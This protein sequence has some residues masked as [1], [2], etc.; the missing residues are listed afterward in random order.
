MGIQWNRVVVG[1]AVLTLSGATTF[2][3]T[4]VLRDGRRIR[5][6][7]RTV[8][9]GVIE[10]AV[11]DSGRLLRID[12]RE[13]AR[14]ELDDEIG[15]HGS[16][17]PGGRPR[18]LRER[19]VSVAANVAWNDTGIDVRAGQD[20][21]FAARGRVRWGPDRRD[22]AA[23]EKN[24]PYNAYRPIPGRPAAALIGKVGE[25]SSDYFFIG[26]DTGPVRMRTRGR[27]FLAINDDYLLDNSG[28][29]TVTVYY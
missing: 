17:R 27:L 15:V 6:D 4:L 7:L 29:L 18:G 19:E 16:G 11:D 13:V 14:I 3:D 8:R 21:Y 10:F 23:G 28:A 22:G 25:E 9:D 26:D 1:L 12:R 20:V 24:S 2:A 5:G